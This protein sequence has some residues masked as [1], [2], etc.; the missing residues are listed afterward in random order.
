[1]RAAS[2]CL[3]RSR[4][5]IAI[6]S[7]RGSVLVVVLVTLV[8]ASIA[9]TLFIE[10]ATDDLL[11]DARAADARRLRLE[12]YSA[13]ETTLAVLQDFKQVNGGLRSPAEGWGE[14]LDW[15]GYEPQGNRRVTVAFEDE[16]GKLSLPRAS[17][18]TLVAL[19]DSWGLKKDEAERLADALQQWAQPD[20]VPTSGLATDYDREKLPYLAPGR[21][22]RSFSELRAIAVAREVFY[23]EAGRPNELWRRF[24]A[25][26]SLLNF[27]A[28]NLN[29]APAGTLAA[30]GLDEAKQAL[31]ADYLAGTGSY[32]S[33]GAGYFRDEGD[34]SRVLGGSAPTGLG[35]EIQALRIR[36][37]VREG[38]GEFQ[39]SALLSPGGGAKAITQKARTRRE[40]GTTPPATTTIEVAR[41]AAATALNYPFTLLEIRENEEPLPEPATAEKNPV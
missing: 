6:R 9:L 19:F 3:A 40:D 10:R 13:L 2:S 23:D 28:S 29:A 4:W 36:V 37:T 16:S 39:L 35:L 30:C 26:V 12:A 41:P 38:G 33:Q 14:P 22:L 31:L 5:P 7:R 20:Y 8:L 24:V 21:S 34:V 17:H 1:M 32:R 25:T 27:A 15:A 18:E 11:V